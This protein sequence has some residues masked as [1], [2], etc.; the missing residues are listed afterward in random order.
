MT[1]SHILDGS[2]AQVLANVPSIAVSGGGA[3]GLKA[4]LV[5][6]DLE[7]KDRWELVAS[8]S[9]DFRRVVHALTFF[10]SFPF[11]SFSLIFNN[12]YIFIIYIF[13]I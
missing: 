11:T 5:W 7:Y 10:S 3:Y 1:L 8:N 12:I 13:I 6:D 4:G 9:V 2:V